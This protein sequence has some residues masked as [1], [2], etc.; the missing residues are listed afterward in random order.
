M[1][2]V[3]SGDISASFITRHPPHF[4]LHCAGV[5]IN[6][7]PGKPNIPQELWQLELTNSSGVSSS[8][9]ARIANVQVHVFK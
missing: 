1:D 6:A 3:S 5:L 8:T 2:K 9:R 4:T 7:H